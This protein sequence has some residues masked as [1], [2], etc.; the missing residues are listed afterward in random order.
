V[1]DDGSSRA[2]WSRPTA[3]AEDFDRPSSARVY[4]FLLGGSAHGAVD[5]DLGRE[6]VLAEPLV[7]AVAREN[8]SFLRRAVTVLVEAGIDQL[9]DLGSGIPTVGGTHEIAR[10]IDPSTRVAYVDID[11]VAVAHGEL[12]LAHEQGL[13]ATWGDLRDPDHVLGAPGVSGLLDFSRPVGL[14]M[15]SVFQHVADGDD[16]PGIVQRYLSRVAAGSALALS[17]LTGDD[18]RIDMVAL[19]RLTEAYPRGT[20]TPRSH[21][22]VAAMVAGVDLL[23]P[24]LVYAAQWRPEHRLARGP[25]REPCC[26]HRAA[27]GFLPP[28]PT[29][30]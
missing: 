11:P 8:R 23:D 28:G 21:G 12:L 10:R 6:M 22:E 17:H 30:A 9:L 4:D 16:P 1:V 25:L 2:S 5:R 20:L 3:R 7:V 18:P 29:E 19:R 14:L 24:G 13:T 15:F 27:V 26:G